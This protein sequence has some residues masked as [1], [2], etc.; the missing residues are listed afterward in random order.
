MKEQCTRSIAKGSDSGLWFILKKKI[1][2][3]QD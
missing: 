2:V 1:D 3:D